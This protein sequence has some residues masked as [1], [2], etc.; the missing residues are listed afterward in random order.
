MPS[1]A[2]FS[3]SM[4]PDER[5]DEDLALLERAEYLEEE[6]RDD[7]DHAETGRAGD[8]RDDA[9]G[10]AHGNDVTVSDREQRRPRKVERTEEPDWR[11]QRTA[12]RVQQQSVA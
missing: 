4:T 9:S 12:Q 11:A 8:D 5:D 7:G 6:G 3:S 10:T 1:R 2:Y